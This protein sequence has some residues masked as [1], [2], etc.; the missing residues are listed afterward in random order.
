MNILITNDD[1]YNAKG[2]HVLA[3]IMCQ[4]GNVTVIAPKYHQSGMTMEVPLRLSQAA[5]KDLPEEKPGKRSYLDATPASCV[6]FGLNVPFLDKFPDVVV[7]GINHGSNAASAAC[8]SGTLGAAAEAALNGVP[9]IGVS[10]D[11]NGPEAD[12]SSVEKFF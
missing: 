8:Y 4:F 1:G 3:E 12:F 11:D 5:Y 10:V 9:A 6:K 2:I 7:S